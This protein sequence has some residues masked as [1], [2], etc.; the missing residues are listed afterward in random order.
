MRQTYIPSIEE[1]AG[2]AEEK[3]NNEGYNPEDPKHRLAKLALIMD[4]VAEEIHNVSKGTDNCTELID[5][6]IRVYSYVGW[7]GLSTN[8]FE[9]LLAQ[10]HEYNKSRPTKH[11]KLVN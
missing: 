4:E 7:I 8:A 1:I 6:I 2:L 10:K 11:G 5:V 3:G 9:L